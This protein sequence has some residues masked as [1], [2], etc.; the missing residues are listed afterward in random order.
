MFRKE[1]SRGKPD[2]PVEVRDAAMR[3]EPDRYIA[4]TLASPEARPALAALAAFAAEVSHIPAVVSEAP[5]GAIRLQWW[6]DALAEGREG[7]LSGHPVADALI[8]AI[9]AHGLP[10]DL[11]EAVIEARELDLSGA[12]PEDDDELDAYLQAT[13]GNIFLLGLCALG[14]E[15]EEVA[16]LAALAGRAYG[17]ARGFCRLPVLLHNGG[18]IL[19]AGRLKAAGI[20]PV[21]LVSQPIP[22]DVVDAVR[23]V[24]DAMA[25]DALEAL[26]RARA[27]ARRLDRRYRPALLPLAMVEPYFQ[28]QSFQRILVET[29]EIAP[30][31]R[32]MRI[33]LAHLTGRL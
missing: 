6:H 31:R 2:V 26:S 9:D 8:A 27:Q 17:I 23:R 24:A 33:G 5:L 14:A 22:P 19:P 15:R 1:T 7:R 32:V 21:Q 10:R 12:M 25:K 18:M 29:V 28:A 11:I 3:G 16:E 20:E 30:L 4:A 13:Q